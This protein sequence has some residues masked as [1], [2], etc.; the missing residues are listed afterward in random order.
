MKRK[1]TPYFKCRWCEK[2]FDGVPEYYTAE[3]LH[4]AIRKN[5]L[6]STHACDDKRQGVGEL[7]GF[8]KL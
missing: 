5:L 2:I 4:E 7:L 6:A 8:R 3:E 1:V